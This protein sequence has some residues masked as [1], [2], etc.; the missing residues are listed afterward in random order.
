MV[1]VPPIAGALITRVGERPLIVIGLSLHAAAMAR[2][3]LI[4]APDRASWQVVAPQIASGAGI[5]CQLRGADLGDE[6]RRPAAHRQGCGHVQHPAPA[7]RGVRCRRLG[8]GV[9]G[10]RR[11]RAPEQLVDWFAAALGACARLSLLGATAELAPPARRSA[12]EGAATPAGAAPAAE[13]D[14]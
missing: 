1:F 5:A 11:R 9:R 12:N 4:A 14:S 6:L 10:R 7:R 13:L 2:I 3:A 8:R